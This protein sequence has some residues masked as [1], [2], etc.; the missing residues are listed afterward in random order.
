MEWI[1]RERRMEFCFEDMRWF[2][3]RRWQ[4]PVVHK[5]TFDGHEQEYR[6]EPG[7]KNYTLPIPK[8]IRDKNP[9]IERLYQN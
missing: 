5:F 2:D 8:K 3:I 7:A 9:V 1:R 4:L 6:L